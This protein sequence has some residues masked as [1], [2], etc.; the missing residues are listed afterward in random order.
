[1]VVVQSLIVA[2]Q[3]YIRLD[4]TVL[5]L[6]IDKN[7]FKNKLKTCLS[8]AFILILFYVILLQL[9]IIYLTFYS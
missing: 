8:I 2:L 5:L 7:K 9:F 3:F 4:A 1:M 6:H